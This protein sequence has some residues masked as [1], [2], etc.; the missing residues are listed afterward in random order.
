MEPLLIHA[1]EATPKVELNPKNNIFLFEGCSRPENVREFYTPVLDWLDRF[2]KELKNNKITYTDNALIFKYKLSYFN[3]SSAKFI[4]DILMEINNFYADGVN[5]KIEWY[6]EEGDE[7]M[8][9]VGEELSEMVHFPFGY[10][11]MKENE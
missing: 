4:L 10:I 7:D 6:F 1:T 5:V 9:D 3:S 11:M 2:R 8:K